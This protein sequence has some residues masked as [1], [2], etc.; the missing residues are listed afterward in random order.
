LGGSIQ[1]FLIWPWKIM[2]SCYFLCHYMANDVDVHMACVSIN[3]SCN[4]NSHDFTIP[5]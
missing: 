3:G 2:I 5:V 4:M 1:K